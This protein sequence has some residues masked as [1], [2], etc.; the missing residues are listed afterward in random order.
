MLKKHMKHRSLFIT[1]GITSAA[2]ILGSLQV[3]AQVLEEIV[4]SA[5]R[6]EQSLQEVP[7]SVEVTSGLELTRQGFRQFED[8]AQFSPSVEINESLHET[9][10]AV[11]GMGNDVANM[12]IEQSAPIFVDG[13]HFGRGSMIKGAFLDLE[14]IEV[15]RG[16]QPVY[17]GQNATA[18]AFSVTTRKPTPEWEGDITSEFGNFGRVSFEGGAGG[19]ITDTLGIRV[20]GKWDRTSGHLKDLV[21]GFNFPNRKD[22]A[23]RVT[24]QWN[25]SENFEALLK[26]EYLQRRSQGD[27]TT[28]CQ[29]REV[30]EFTRIDERAPLIRGAVP[31]WDAIVQ[32]RPIPNCATDGFTKAGVMEGSGNFF[33]PVP[34]FRNG[35]QR[36]GALDIRDVASGIMPDGDL[37]AREPLDAWNYRL[38]LTYTFQNDIRLELISGLI[39]YERDTFESSDESP[40]LMEAAFRTEKFDM[41]SQEIRI[42]SP[43]GGPFEWSFGGYYQREDLDLNPVVTLRAVVNRPLRTHLP[44][45]DSEWKSAF[46]NFTFNFWDDRASL[47]VGGRF[48]HVKKHG[49]I[50]G[51]AAMWVFDINPDPDGD[52]LVRSTHTDGT[53]RTLR[54]VHAPSGAN[55]F[56]IDCAIGLDHMGRDICS[57]YGPGYYSNVYRLMTDTPDPW[58]IQKPVGLGVIRNDMREPANGPFNDKLSDSNFDPQVTLRYRHTPEQSFYGKWA[59]AFK[60]GGFDTSDREMPNGG[61]GTALG[62]EEFSFRAEYAENFELGARGSLFNGTVRY[63][64]T[65]FQQTIKDLQIETEIIDLARIALGD[66][67]TG[68]GQTNAGKQRTQGLEIDGGWAISDFLTLN[69]G[70]VIMKGRM[71]DYIGGCTEVEFELADTNDCISEAESIALY[72]GPGAAGFIDRSGQQAPRTPKWKFVAGLDYWQPISDRLKVI[73]NTKLAY[74]DK[75]TEDTLGFSYVKAWPVHADW[76]IMLGIASQDD[77]WKINGYVRNILGSRI[78]YNADQDLSNVH[79]V[80][81]DD[82]TSSGYTNYGV[83]FGYQ[84]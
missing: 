24:L 25:P 44:W 26:A 57:S 47:D 75:Y 35:D 21:N 20:A 33:A 15:L 51:E 46:G 9:S 8:L 5:Q 65:L 16:P 29:S 84:F 66:V 6:R 70:G 3:H 83:Q 72:G 7:I 62:Q 34:G 4:V 2:V 76:N 43:T 64:V 18:G 50:S 19:P 69:F 68:R 73:A 82:I 38:G 12:S 13:I 77:T 40:F 58:N 48:T 37:T 52:G 32:Q 61:I 22:Q 1:Y 17:F 71:L 49:A 59:R 81:E 23:G 53:V 45:N 11:R 27:P 30:G 78:G 55:R 60:A 10:I 54:F 28:V 14:R 79:G 41:H 63:G 67:A 39:D 31:A 74:S 80:V 56:L 42:S 36:T